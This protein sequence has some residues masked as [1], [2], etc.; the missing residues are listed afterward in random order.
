MAKDITPKFELLPLKE[1]VFLPENIGFGST[2][3]GLGTRLAST[4]TDA[5]NKEG[6]L[7]KEVINNNLDTNAKT[8]LGEF[9]FGASGALAI[10]TDSD[11]GLWIS[12]TGILAKKAGANT[13]TVTNSGDVAMVGSITISNPEDINGSE[14]N[15]DSS[16]TD[17]SSLTTFVDGVY[18]SDISGLQSQI[19][20]QITTWFYGYVPTL[21]NLPASDWTTDILKDAHLGDLFYD[22]TTGYAYRFALTTGTYSWIKLVNSDITEAL[23]LAATAQDTAD[24]KRRVF[25]AEP[26]TPYNVGDLWLT[27]LVDLT[28]DFKKCITEKLTGAYDSAHWVIASKYTDDTTANNA[29]SDAAQ[30][31]SDA[32]TAQGTADGKVTTFYQTTAPTAEG[33]GDLWVDTDNGNLL[34]RW[35]G[36]WREV[37]DDDIAQAIS[38]ASTAQTT[39]DGKIVSFYTDEPP[40]ADGIGDFWTDTNDNNK[41]Y[42]WNGSNW[43]SIRD[44][45]IA[46][47]IS[48]A[49]TAQATADGKI[50]TFYQDTE[51]SGSI[52]DLWVDTDDGN[53]L[54]RYSGSTWIEIQDEDI[55]NALS[56]A[57]TAQSTA[58]GKIVSFYATTAPTAE[59]TGDLWF[60]TDDDMR[61]YRWNGSTWI[62]INNPTNW[63]DVG[64]DGNKPDDNADV[65]YNNVAKSV[66]GQGDLALRS[67]I[68]AI[69]CDTTIISGGKII[70]G[71]LTASNIQTGTLSSLLVQT[72]T[73]AYSGIKMSS[74]LGGI[75]CYGQSIQFKDTSNNLRG[76]LGA[77][78]TQVYFIG[79]SGKEVKIGSYEDIVLDAAAGFSVGPART[80][81]DLG[82]STYYWRTA[83]LNKIKLKYST[84]NPSGTGDIVNYAS[85]ITDQFRGIP[86]DGTWTGSFDMSAY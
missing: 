27:S 15:N 34:R 67:T 7:V 46:T 60:D 54:Y 22:N 2:I 31:I 84:T 45:G 21:L 44:A 39:A 43:I 80:N 16:W 66:I 12:P 57:S 73:S 3:G 69:D 35:D 74:S 26:T 10:T 25:T 19:D 13:F 42:R 20:G 79:V 28:G 61:P 86:G 38:D 17:D 36:T 11:N 51:P 6:N 83:Y 29:A 33:I 47:A 4:V 58:D 9:T 41:L 49:A 40:T 8:I 48:N 52:G 77:S 5:I 64:D 32:A 62:D 18:S 63:A 72:S 75:A 14:I 56:N 65:T 37:Q 70:T 50:I 59:G 85:G 68:R 1:K 71:L 30:A 81:V 78:S 76:Y 55:A 24:N 53:K 23:A 82:N